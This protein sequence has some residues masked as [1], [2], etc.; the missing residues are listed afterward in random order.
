LESN[1][2]EPFLVFRYCHDLPPFQNAFYGY[3]KDKD[4]WMMQTRRAGWHY[5]QISTAYIVH[6]PH[7]PSKARLHFNGGPN[8]KMLDK[9]KV[10]ATTNTSAYK[11]FLIDRTY[12]NFRNWLNVTAP[13][14]TVVRL[15]NAHKSDDADL[16][17]ETPQKSR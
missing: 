7:L 13:D 17:L 6:Y 12:I 10:T 4:A 1:R 9:P 15:C 2:Y 5:K 8:G 11:R 16:W 14:E 3:G